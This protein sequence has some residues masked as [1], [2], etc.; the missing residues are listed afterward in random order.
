LGELFGS[1]L[2]S[3]LGAWEIFG[4]S[5]GSIFGAWVLFGDFAELFWGAWEVFGGL[6]RSSLGA[7]ELFEELFGDFAELFG[8]GDFCVFATVAISIF[9]TRA[10]HLDFVVTG[11]LSA[12][13]LLT[14]DLG[15][16]GEFGRPA[17]GDAAITSA[18]TLMKSIILR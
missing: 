1:S 11:V 13:P 10:G 6:F 3:T 16:L 14:R 18:A 17:T 8:D 4:S 2:G 15:D 5:L 7:W 12:A 9:L